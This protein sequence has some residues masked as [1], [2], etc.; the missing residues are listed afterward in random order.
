MNTQITPLVEQAVV[1]RM[2]A[3]ASFT[4]LDISNALKSDR[5]PIKHGDVA[6]IVRD[7]YAS[8]A[9]AF[10]DFDRRLIDV[11]TE[12]GAKKAQ[13]FLYLHRETREREYTARG[14]D[15]LP[16][17]PSAQ[18]RDL[19]DCV[20]AGPVTPPWRS[21]RPPRSCG[22]QGHRQQSRRDGAL[23]IP[24]ALVVRLGW[25]IGATLAL[26][27]QPGAL[28]LTPTNQDGPVRVWDD[29]RIRLCQRKLRLGAL[30]A[31]NVTMEIDDDGL[32]IS[33]GEV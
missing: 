5:Y 3:R 26:D 24:R 17:V 29:L 22:S 9:M 28:K 14:Q 1:E 30:T 19:S 33:A 6:G 7:I 20:P 2:R 27:S 11:V 25:N 32:K 8:G 31:G 12:E 18:A 10:Y 15:S 21:Q 16:L 4:A 23:A 13:A